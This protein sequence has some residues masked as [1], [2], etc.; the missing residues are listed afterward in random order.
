M[1]LGQHQVGAGR[2]IELAEAKDLPGR[3]RVAAPEP[4]AGRL[5]LM[6]QRIQLLPRRIAERRR[7][8]TFMGH[9]PW[10]T[11]LVQGRH[12]RVA[13]HPFGNPVPLPQ[14]A[15]QRGGH[16]LA[17]RAVET[18]AAGGVIGKG[19][20]QLRPGFDLR[21][22]EAEDRLDR[23]FLDRDDPPLGGPVLDDDHRAGGQVAQPLELAR[24]HHAGDRRQ[25]SQGHHPL[26]G[27]AQITQERLGAGDRRAVAGDH[28]K[29]KH[30]L[31][32]VCPLAMASHVAP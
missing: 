1:R 2:A 5:D 19:S 6:D 14:G 28:A 8:A 15:G 12:H 32:G 9:L 24:E 23:A 3:G 27:P 7:S 18:I 22:E 13:R 16:L 25:V 29:S 4:A 20:R 31:P 30:H 21:R 10:N 11:P 17:L 26:D